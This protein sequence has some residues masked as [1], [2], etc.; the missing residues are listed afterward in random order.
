MEGVVAGQGRQAAIEDPQNSW[1]GFRRPYCFGGRWVGGVE[2]GR[3]GVSPQMGVWRRS[4]AVPGRKLRSGGRRAPT[5]I[6]GN[7]PAPL[8]FVIA[9]ETDVMR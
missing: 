2:T 9:R 4:P 5:R 3:C 8:P 6:D 1:A 7:A